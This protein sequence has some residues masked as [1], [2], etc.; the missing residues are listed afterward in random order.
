M[1]FQKDINEKM[2]AILIDWII[3]VHNKFHLKSQTLYQAI[4]LIDTY[5]SLKIIKLND[6]Q[7]LG[8]GCLYIASK[9]R[10]IYYPQMKEWVEETAGAYKKE[11][12]IRI[13][14]DIL[15]TTN[16]NLLPP[17]Q[18]DFYNIISK[19]FGFNQKQHYFGKYFMEN[20]LMDYNM[21]KYPPSV[22]AVSCCYIVMKFFKIPNYKILYSTHI[23]Y[24]NCPQKIIK[25][26]S[27]ELCFL[28]RNLNLSEFKA[29]KEKYSSE[30]YCKVAEYCSV[31]L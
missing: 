25:D 9:F 22:I 13:E 1:K 8:L 27:R 11:D 31:D 16:Y 26:T 28:V 5:L 23:I 18:D 14:K 12:L 19:F 4:W 2:R 17:S 15:R 10:E 29:I 7:L 21:I 6:F 24:G 30:E 20:S 3:V